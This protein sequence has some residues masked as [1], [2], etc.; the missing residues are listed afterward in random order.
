MNRFVVRTARRYLVLRRS[1]FSGPTTPILDIPRDTYPNPLFRMDLAQVQR[2]APAELHHLL[3]IPYQLLSETDVFCGSVV[4]IVDEQILTNTKRT[5]TLLLQIK[6]PQLLG[7]ISDGL[8]KRFDS[9][10][11]KMSVLEYMIDETSPVFRQTFFQNIEDIANFSAS[12]ERASILLG[13][14]DKLVSVGKVND[15]PLLLSTDQWKCITSYVPPTSYQELYTFLVHLNIQT[16]YPSNLDRIKRHLLRGSNIAKLVARTGWLNPRWHDTLRAKFSEEHQ[17][18]MVNFFTV[19]DLLQFALHDIAHNDV[20]NANLYLNMLVTK[21][22]KKSADLLGGVSRPGDTSISDDIQT[23]LHVI[24]NH[25]MT[26]K[27][28]SN[29]LLVLR[30]MV[31]NGLPLDPKTLLI[32][33]KNL[34]L[35]GRL[36]D[37]LL[38][39]NSIPPGALLSDDKAGLALEIIR[40]ITAKYPSLPKVLIGYVVA[41][42]PESVELINRLGLISLAYTGELS[43]YDAGRVS[44]ATIDEALM[45]LALPPEV[46][47][48]LYKSVLSDAQTGPELIKS[49]FERYHEAASDVE[50]S[51]VLGRRLLNDDV[52]VILI[53]KLISLGDFEFVDSPHAFDTTKSIAKVWL[54]VPVKRRNRSVYLYDMLIWASLLHY[55][56]YE[57]SLFVMQQ[58]HTAGLPFTFNQIFPFIKYHYDR[59]E[60][61]LAEKWYNELVK[62]GAKTTAAPAKQL[63]SMAR[64]RKWDVNGFA[65]R[66]FGIHKNKEKHAAAHRLQHDPI[67]GNIEDAVTGELL[68]VDVNF[69]DE[70]SQILHEASVAR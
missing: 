15:V 39:I 1:P 14:L 50:P 69:S 3:Q 56:D 46:L 59:N 54:A 44:K 48:E 45:G 17:H 49:L 6:D 23:V 26:F 55:N 64:A 35:Q 57:F 34:R 30:H 21:F 4:D 24:L 53:K 40:V 19:K 63:F 68:N 67:L 29:G 60:F 61:D 16:K 43:A 25:V 33:V 42:F 11:V 31:K 41:I 27:G 22:E 2:L 51:H 32:M 8:R 62:S 38:L 37:S 9:D 47:S 10:K 18:R 12:S 58:A 66:K 20:V 7:L 70:L 5:H 36:D 52:V 65:Y 28:A 13:Y